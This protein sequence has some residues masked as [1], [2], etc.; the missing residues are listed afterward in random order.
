[1]RSPGRSRRVPCSAHLCRALDI[2]CE[3]AGARLGALDILSE[4]ETARLLRDGE[5][6]ARPFPRRCIHVLFEEQAARAPEAI[7]VTMGDQHL[8]YGQLNAR[9]CAGPAPARRGGGAGRAGSHCCWTV[10]W[11]WWSPSLPC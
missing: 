3:D 7:A 9:Q 8:T 10:R 1:M 11:T 2:L 4:D 5:G 6:P